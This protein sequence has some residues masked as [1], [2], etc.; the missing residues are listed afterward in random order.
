MLVAPSVTKTKIIPRHCK[1]SLGEAEAELLHLQWKWTAERDLLRARGTGLEVP[2]G[3][4]R[5]QLPTV[6]QPAESEQWIWRKG[7]EEHFGEGKDELCIMDVKPTASQT[8]GAIFHT[9]NSMN[10]VSWRYAM[11]R[12]G[13]KLFKSSY[14]PKYSINFASFLFHSILHM[15]TNALRIWCLKWG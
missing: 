2:A 8:L 10:S 5:F 4:A 3:P 13:Y 7:K 11:D 15:H 12:P 1:C 14:H 6:P 9:N